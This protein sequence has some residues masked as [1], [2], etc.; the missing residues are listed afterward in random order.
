MSNR[1]IAAFTE[2][3]STGIRIGYLL[4]ASEEKKVMGSDLESL[5]IRTLSIE[6]IGKKPCWGGQRV[7]RRRMKK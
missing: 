3:S 6:W 7:T 4:M 1:L 2:L 5:C